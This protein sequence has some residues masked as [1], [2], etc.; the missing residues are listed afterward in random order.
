MRNEFQIFSNDQLG[1]VRVQ[2]DNQ[3]NPWFCLSDVCDILGLQNPAK[4]SSR[5][6]SEGITLT[7]TLTNGGTQ[8]LIFINEANLYK[9]IMASRKPEAEEFQRWVCYEVIPSLRKNGIAV[10]NNLSPIQVL[11]AITEQITVNANNIFNLQNDLSL[12]KNDV[13]ELK[14]KLEE[15]RIRNYYDNLDRR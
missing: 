4:V 15:M 10:V 11:K 3:G 8:N 6:F 2:M 7:Y 5:L 14:K 12:T 1:S 13:E 9:V